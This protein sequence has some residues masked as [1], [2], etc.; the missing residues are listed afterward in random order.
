LSIDKLGRVWSWGVGSEGE[1]GDGLQADRATP[2]PVA[3][4]TDVVSLAAADQEVLALRRDGSLVGW[5]YHG[6]GS[7]TDNLLAGQI[8]VPVIAP[9]VLG[10]PSL[11]YADAALSNTS[12][13]Y[14]GIDAN[15][16]VRLWGDTNSGLISCHQTSGGTPISQPYAPTGLSN[17]TQIAGGS[18]YALFLTKA[19]SVLGCGYNGDGQ[20]GDGTTSSTSQSTTP[21]KPGPVAAVGLP[22]SIMSVAAGVYASGALD[23]S[24]NVYTWGRAGTSMLSGQGDGTLPGNNTSPV[25]LAINAGAMTD[26]PAVFAGTQ[27]GAASNA[28]I[29]VGLAVAP[30]HRGEMGQLYIAAALPDGTLLLL[31][32]KGNFV[33]YAPAK[34]LPAYYAGALP[35]Q[36]PLN[37]GRNMNLS[38]LVGTTVIVGYGLGAGAAAD[39]DLLANNRYKQVLKL[40]P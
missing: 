33:P 21:A 15:G 3:G 4:L 27:D 29:D 26:A 22:A 39:Q 34:P 31:D 20:L 6:S 32:A 19:G 16:Q 28:T 12:G 17:I 37:L 5:G 9:T 35:R 14:L 30:A 25:K 40:A 36:A 24:G 13:Q 38:G 11:V 7:T 1:L 2:Q 10:V 18:V 8:G 23:S